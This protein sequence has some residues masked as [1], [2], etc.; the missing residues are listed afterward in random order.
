MKYRIVAFDP[1]TASED[2]LD[3]CFDFEDRMFRELDLEDPLPLRECRHESIGDTNP[4][5]KVLRWVVIGNVDGQ[6]E[7]IGKSEIV[8]VT[9]KDVDCEQYGHIAAIRLDVDERFRRRGI[10]T[11]L[12]G[13]LVQKAV[14]ERSVR[15]IETFSFQESGWRFCAKYGGRVA[16]EATQRR[17]RLAEV[18]WAVMEEWR[19]EGAKRSEEK[20]TRL[21]SFEVVPEEMLEEFV[22]LYNEIVD[23]VPLGE[24]E[25]REKVTPTLRREAEARVGRGWYTKVSQEADGSLSGLT[26][27][28]HDSAMPYRVEQE[29]TGVRGE[30]RGRGLGKWLKAEMI[31][32]IRDELPEARYINTGNAD[33]NA[34]MVSINERMGF[35]RYQ[36]E[37]CFRFELEALHRLFSV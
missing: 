10:G 28:V 18:D 36:T 34:A 25:M 19:R 27:I 15:T 35:K 22:D 2:L 3:K 7:V 24:L 5:R 14:E 12:F 13:L 16:L 32:F 29:L 9:E 33:T 26:E 1:G 6:E 20:G 8:F 17:L 37:L 21:R 23:E 4:R 31:F 30:Y 11:E